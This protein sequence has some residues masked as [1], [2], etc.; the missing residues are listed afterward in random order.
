MSGSR[1][2]T[3]KFMSKRKIVDNSKL[4]PL[5]RASEFQDHSEAYEDKITQLRKRKIKL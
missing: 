5:N 4:I 3:R 1:L 2:P